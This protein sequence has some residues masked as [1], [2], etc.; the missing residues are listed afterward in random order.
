M[1]SKHAA[2]RLRRKVLNTF[3]CRLCSADDNAVCR[4]ADFR[5]AMFLQCSVGERQCIFSVS[6]ASYAG[7]SF[8]QPLGVAGVQSPMSRWHTTGSHGNGSL[9]SH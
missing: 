3:C 2:V 4:F 9:V 7:L 5:H 8:S 6:L 1:H